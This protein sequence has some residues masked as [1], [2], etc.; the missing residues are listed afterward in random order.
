[1]RAL[2]MKNG[3]VENVAV[4]DTLPNAS[5]GWIEAPEGV[6]IGWRS[7]GNGTFSAPVIA[8]APESTTE[9]RVG[10]IEATLTPGVLR[11][12]LLGDATAL[13]TVRNAD[14]E[15]EELRS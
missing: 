13:A 5:S 15:I 3:I 6:G 7:N 2:K 10:L 1:M 14:D 9:Q 12:A 8:P 4:F 11:K